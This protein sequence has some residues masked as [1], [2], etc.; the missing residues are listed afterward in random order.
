MGVVFTVM[1]GFGGLLLEQAAA[2]SVDL[3]SDCVLYGQLEDILWFAGTGWGAFLEPAALAQLPRELV[4][5][6]ALTLLCVVLLALFWKELRLTT[7]DPA[8]ASRRGIPASVFHYGLLL[9]VAFAP[10][11]PFQAVGSTPFPATLM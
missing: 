6:A 7:F 4:T 8:L 3:D 2:R 5:L 10:L 1:F 11:S 9:L